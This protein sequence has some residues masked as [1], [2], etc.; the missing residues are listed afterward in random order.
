MSTNSPLTNLSRIGVAGI[1]VGGTKIQMCYGDPD[2]PRQVEVRCDEYASL[3]AALS[4]CLQ[5]AG[6][7]PRTLV[8]GVAGRVLP[9]GDVQVTNRPGWPVFRR[10]A[11]AEYLR[12]ELVVVNDLVAMAV[13]TGGL[14]AAGYRLLLPELPRPDGRARVVVAIGT[15]VGVAVV[16]AHGTVH[17]TEAGH[18]PWQPIT[19]V[20]QDLLSFLRRRIPSEVITVEQVLGGLDGFRHLYDHLVTRREPPVRQDGRIIAADGIPPGPA[21]T[22]A[23]L[24]GEELSR[25]LV[26][27]YAGILGQFLRTLMLTLLPEGGE[28]WLGGSV[29]QAPGLCDLLM[30]DGI[31]R[32]R[33]VSAGTR[34]D[35]LLARTP[36]VLIRDRAVAARGALIYGCRGC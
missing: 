19:T 22:A 8:A 29:L 31:L 23:A 11:F 12:N 21:I 2:D 30:A 36:L 20:E 24:A 14:G 32:E 28:V 26:R 35:D 9:G 3:E 15:G 16:D 25:E 4:D 5:R 27:I 17:A 13:G 33:F 10:A 6:G 7:V 1:D 18:I 34:H